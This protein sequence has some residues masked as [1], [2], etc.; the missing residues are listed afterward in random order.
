M[1]NGKLRAG[2]DGYQL[3]RH[4]SGEKD[5]VGYARISTPHQ[6]VRAQVRQLVR[7]GCCRVYAEQASAYGP[8][9][10]WTALLG[11]IRSG[12]MIIV[13]ALDRLA[14]TAGELQACARKLMDGGAHLVALADDLDWRTPAQREAWSTMLASARRTHRERTAQG[15][16]A[17][18]ERGTMIGR[19]TVLTRNRILLVR[20]LRSDGYSLRSIAAATGMS[21]GTVRKALSESA[22]DPSHGRQLPLVSP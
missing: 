6:D 17:A 9:P 8:R 1:R 11:D 19:P 3:T 7:A 20:K 5:K 18:R 16:D 21:D 10:G 12:D 4:R 22:P 14:R 13:T 15:I 2:A